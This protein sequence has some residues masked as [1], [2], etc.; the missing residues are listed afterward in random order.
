MT[1]HLPETQPRQA[2]LIAGVGYL[3]IF[4]LAI[5]ANFFVRTGLVET[6]DAAATA[7]N[8]ME[9]EGLFRAGLVAFL[10]I[11]LVDVAV[12][13]GLY[14]LFRS[15]QRDL[16]LLTA[17]FRIVYTVFLGVALIFFFVVLQ[18]LGDAGPLA[19]FDPAQLEAQALLSLDAFN[20]TWLIGLAA[21]GVHLILLGWL[22]LASGVVPRLLGFVLMLAG[23]A[24]IVDTVAH[25]VLANYADVETLFLAIVA[26]PS[27]IGELWLAIWLLLRGGRQAAAAGAR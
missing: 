2:A 13:W 10:I 23:A 3:V 11:F 9:S 8:I 27:V 4:V 22:A 25:G 14:I 7:T 21:F 1:T 12:A 17:W 16:S 24:Y 26:I 20:Y 18:L 6:G 19:A 15:T 5:F